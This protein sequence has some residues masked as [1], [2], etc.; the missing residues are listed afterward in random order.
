MRALAPGVWVSPQLPLEALP[1]V[2]GMGVRR[3]INN[4]PDD[5]EPGQPSSAEMEAAARAAGLDYLWIPVR[6][7]PA[8]GEAAA[9]G[10]ALDD[11]A[12]T[13]LF[14]RSGTR[15][16]AAWAMARCARGDDPAAVRAAAADAGYDLARLPL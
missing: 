6:G 16:A 9:V 3:V 5:E 2:A 11:G 13:L 4:R 14:C 15:S 12:P 10:E 8:S 7:L 1:V